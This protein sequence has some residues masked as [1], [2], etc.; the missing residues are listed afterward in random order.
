[1]RAIKTL[2]DAVLGIAIP[3]LIVL[4]LAVAGMLMFPSCR[5]VSK[6]S[7]SSEQ[8]TDSS[9]HAAK[10]SMASHAKTAT[11][12]KVKDS[13]GEKSKDSIH[14]ASAI[15]QD[16]V[17]LDFD[18]SGNGGSPYGWINIIDNGDS[19]QVYTGG[20]KLKSLTATRSKTVKDSTATN[21]KANSN[22][23]TRDSS[24]EKEK[25][26]SNVNKEKDTD[27]NKDNKAAAA[28][29]IT[30]TPWWVIGLKGVLL[31]VGFGLVVYL[32]FFCK[33]AFT[34]IPPFITIK[35]K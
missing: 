10:D 24:V 1:M 5:T 13:S 28:S 6:A 29:S 2:R 17:T 21:K 34:P 3:L 19:L 8:K 23:Q 20:R 18:T 11:D 22:V 33:I 25:D 12:V 31:L 35:R 27:L 7:S 32:V 15:T 14:T 9:T 30:E 16:G 26:T 4:L